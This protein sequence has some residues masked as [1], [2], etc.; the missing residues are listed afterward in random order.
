[1]RMFDRLRISVTTSAQN[2]QTA[3][4]PLTILLSL[5]ALSFWLRYA[6]EL[7]T[8]RHDGKSRHDPDYI[9]SGA[10][11]RKLDAAGTLQYTL[12]ARELRHYP[13]KDTTEFIEPRLQQFHPS[14]PTVTVRA[15]RGQ[16]TAR[17]QRIDLSEAV[18]VRRA[19]TSKRGELIV[20]TPELTVLTD[21]ERAYTKRRILIRQDKSSIE[22]VGMQFDNKAQTYLLEAQVSGRIESLLSR[23]K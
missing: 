16:S 8:E 9:I 18:E 13:D 3:I 19:A 12:I 15:G 6:S 11:V 1:M 2:W 4:L 10:T 20:E 14:R 17:G 7:P 23:K 5:A 22:G 21:E